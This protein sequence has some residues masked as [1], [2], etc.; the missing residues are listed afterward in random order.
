MTPN[1]EGTYTKKKNLITA[2]KANLT[3]IR[4]KISI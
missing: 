4:N 2:K 1:E 3:L